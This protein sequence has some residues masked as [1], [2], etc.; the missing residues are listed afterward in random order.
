ML[1][2]K[3]TIYLWS[4]AVGPLAD[5]LREDNGHGH[6]VAMAFRAKTLLPCSHFNGS[7]L[8]R[9][10]EGK[11]LTWG[12]PSIHPRSQVTER[13]LLRRMPVLQTVP[14][15]WP[16][17]WPGHLLRRRCSAYLPMHPTGCRQDGF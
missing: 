15:T 16:I 1:Q 9:C 17:G 5:L 14:E 6:E 2:F 12:L 13:R 8:I 4:T 11:T 10:Q 3:G 7:G